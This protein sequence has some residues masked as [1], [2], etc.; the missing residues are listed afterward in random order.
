MIFMAFFTV[1]IL[2]SPLQLDLKALTLLR[3]FRIVEPIFNIPY[4]ILSLRLSE[5]LY[6]NPVRSNRR[7][8]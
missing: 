4:W 7:C 3:S 1:L 8:R 2:P 5:L 6:F